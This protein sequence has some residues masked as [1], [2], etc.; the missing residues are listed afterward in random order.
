MKLKINIDCGNAAFADW[1]AA[2]QARFILMTSTD[3]IAAMDSFDP[4]FALPLFYSNGN[5]VGAASVRG[6]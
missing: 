5:R 6:E 4:L 1:G 2:R 3:S